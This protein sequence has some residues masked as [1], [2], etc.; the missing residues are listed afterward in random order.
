[1]A[2]SFQRYN[3]LIIV[4]IVVGLLG[5]ATALRA[6]SAPAASTA[7]AADELPDQRFTTI[8]DKNISLHQF[9]GKTIL[10]HFW[11]TWCPPCVK[12]LPDLLEAVRKRPDVILIAVSIEHNKTAI[13]QF[14]SQMNITPSENVNFVMDPDAAIIVGKP[15]NHYPTTVVIGSNMTIVDRIN[16]GV[17]W[18]GGYSF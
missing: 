3:G 14:L 4:S 13:T 18:Q 10:V 11:G 16:S 9:K 12:E 5:G 8:N 15:V 17:D 2:R 7:V 6:M 1:M